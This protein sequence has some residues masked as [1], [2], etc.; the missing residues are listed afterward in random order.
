VEAGSDGGDPGRVGD[1]L[2]IVP[3]NGLKTV[4]YLGKSRLM[5]AASIQTGC[6]LT[7][8]H[9]TGG[10]HFQSASRI[11]T[12]TRS[13]L[14]CSGALTGVPAGIEPVQATARFSFA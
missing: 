9:F 7:T 8:A 4:P 1:G 10:V 5:R 14:V 11:T 13:P 2:S 6:S 3:R 12:W